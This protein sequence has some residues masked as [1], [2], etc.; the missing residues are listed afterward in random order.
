MKDIK[1][2][3]IC[4]SEALYPTKIEYVYGIKREYPTTFK[5]GTVSSPHWKPVIRG[6]DCK[7]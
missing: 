7:N 4:G 6:K 3:P 1:L 5:C 2:C